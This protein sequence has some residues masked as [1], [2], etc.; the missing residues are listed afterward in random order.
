MEHH[1]QQ[2]RSVGRQITPCH[3]E[4][5]HQDRPK[6]K[7]QDG[8]PAEVIAVSVHCEQRQM[9]PKV[10][11]TCL[12]NSVRQKKHL[13]G[14]APF[15]PTKRL[16]RIVGRRDAIHIIFIMRRLVRS[17]ANSARSAEPT[18]DTGAS[19]LRRPYRRPQQEGCSQ[20]DFGQL[21]PEALSTTA[22][23]WAP[24]K[25]STG[26]DDMTTCPLGASIGASP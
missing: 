20:A 3:N 5:F 23:V 6:Q 1:H 17:S 21:S 14:Y 12:L 16:G 10:Y 7:P 24:M 2:E 19:P 25:S 18:T 13:V 26:S 4:G 8:W 15:G 11:T 9:P 22:I